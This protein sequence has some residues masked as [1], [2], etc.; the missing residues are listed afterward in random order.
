M[1]NSGDIVKMD[2]QYKAFLDANDYICGELQIDPKR[3]TTQRGDYKKHSS[4]FSTCDGDDYTFC[5][6]FESDRDI[7]DVKHMAAT[8]EIYYNNHSAIF[9][10]T[11]DITHLGAHADFLTKWATYAIHSFNQKRDSKDLNVLFC[12]TP[13]RVYGIPNDMEWT[14]PELYHF[15]N[16]INAVQADNVLIYKFR[17]VDQYTKYRSFSYG[18]FQGSFWVFFL[19]VGGLDSGGANRNL[20]QVENLIESM[21]VSVTEECID[22]D[23]HEL[24]DFLAERIAPFE[25]RKRG[26]TSFQLNKIATH[27]F[28]PIFSLDYSK[29]LYIYE[30]G[31][32]SRALRDL[33][34]LLQTAMEFICVKKSIPIDSKPNID[35][36]RASLIEKNIIDGK[37][38]V[39]YCAFTQ[40]ANVPAHKVYSPSGEDDVSDEQLKTAIVI[41]VQL[42]AKLEDVLPT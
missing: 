25:P 3:V 34:A 17:H 10:K 18:F 7:S 40:T 35:K 23:Y 15:V 6:Y 42:I 33:R 37:M 31:D 5:L 11:E 24:E 1:T 27:K 32:Y 21:S 39:W 38:T 22:V 8:I 41:G 2:Q 26:T 14:W 16:G 13:I 29:F 20:K 9:R 19:D 30:N 4:H 28:G 36:L 12:N